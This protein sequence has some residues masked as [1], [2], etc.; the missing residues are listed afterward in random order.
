[1]KPFT[2]WTQ[3]VGFLPHKVTVYEN[4]EREGTLYLR[5][6]GRDAQGRPQWKKE[7]LRRP[8]RTERGKIISETQQ[9]ALDQAAKK[10]ALLVGGIPADEREPVHQLTLADGIKRA[11]NLEIGMYP[12]DSLHRR[13]VVRELE[14]A[15]RCLGEETRW[16]AIKRADLRRLW[17]WRIQQLRA[18]RNIGLRGAEVTVQRLLAVAAWLT[19]E[20]AIPSGACVA[21]TNWKD[22]LREDWQSIAGTEATIE[23]SRPRHSLDEMRALFGVFGKVDPRFELLMALGAELRL[24]QVVRG[25]RSDL[26][27][28]HRT[29]TVRGRKQKRG[30]VVKLTAGQMAAVERALHPESGYLRELEKN[31]AD[32]SLFP[33]G[34]MPGGRAHARGFGSRSDSK[35]RVPDHPVATVTRHGSAKPL[36]RS[37]FDDWFREAERLA[38]IPHIDG[39][40]AYGLRRRSVDE[41]K[42]LGV[43]REA[44]QEAGGWADTQVPDRIY[45]DKVQEHARDEAA[46]A[47]AK[48]RG[49]GSNGV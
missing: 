12:A 39:R 25:R 22:L 20:E 42:K 11:L 30:T 7:S 38:D 24:G 6:R 43:S 14:R 8:I 35:W 47:R 16:D 1:M 46:A 4:M 13:E 21:P 45:A 27:L 19:D 33:A 36:D 32:Y 15:V 2:P 44:L 17:R 18:E 41:L 48:V 10:Y 31:L 28:E 37:V 5:W 23:P 26:D 3:S 40:G 9:W 29:F 49:E 34:Q